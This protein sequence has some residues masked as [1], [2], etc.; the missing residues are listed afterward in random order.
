MISVNVKVQM[1]DLEKFIGSLLNKLLNHEGF[2][3]YLEPLSILW[4]V[5]S[6]VERYEASLRITSSG[7]FKMYQPVQLI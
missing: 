4:G 1:I 7:Y 6:G 3:H 5:V 2:Y